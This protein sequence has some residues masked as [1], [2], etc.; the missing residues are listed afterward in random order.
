LRL[1]PLAAQDATPAIDPAE[2]ALTAAVINLVAQQAADGGFV[3][4]SGSS[5]PGAT[6][7]AV[8]A[9]AAAAGR[10]IAVE[11]SMTALFDALDYLEREAAAYASIGPGQAA[12]LVL[13]AIAGG[14]DPVGFG[15]VDLLA[16]ARGETPATPVVPVLPDTYGDDLYDHALVLLA[17]AA[18]GEPVAPAAIAALRPA[19]LADGS[20]SFAGTT[21]PGTG[22]SNTTALLVQA[23]IAAGHGADPMVEPALAYLRSVQTEDG[24]FAFQAASPLVPDANSSAL[25]VQAIIAAGQDPTSIEWRD[26]L[27][28]VIAFQN[29]GGAFRYQDADPADNI[30]ATVQAIPALAGLPLPVAVACPTAATTETPAAIAN[31]TSCVMLEAA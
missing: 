23:L 14:R 3:G 29:P 9:L 13:A 27:A 7:D 2:V 15:G 6:T 11:P 16:A 8:Y 30:F 26:A 18:A 31:R 19:Q 5:D 12:K 22:D 17:L 28:G 24:Q 25:A 21:D 10:G 1:Q 20:W 4:F